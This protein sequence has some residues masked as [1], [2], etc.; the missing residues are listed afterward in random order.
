M[1][2][3][4]SGAIS[5]SQICTEFQVAQ[6]TPLSS[7]YRGGAI[8]PNIPANNGVPTSGALSLSNFYNATRQVPLSTGG[9]SSTSKLF[10]LPEATPAPSAISVTSDAIT[11]TPAGGTGGPYTCTWSHLSGDA[12][13]SNPA[14]NTFAPTFT[15]TVTKFSVKAAV[16]RC[17]YT[18]GI[19]AATFDVSVSL[20][21]ES[22]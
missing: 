10:T 13:V 14:A 7:F 2:L 5:L 22:T 18:D 4:A 9:P 19:Q 3:Q 20:R 21:Y 11:L 6:T 12:T 16:K 15:A 17:S 8:V 1:P